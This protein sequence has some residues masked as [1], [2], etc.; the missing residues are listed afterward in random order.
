MSDMPRVFKP[1]T[2][3]R[4][5]VLLSGAALALVLAP[6]VQA[7]EPVF[8][9]EFLAKN[10]NGLQ[11][12]DGDYSDWIEICN[13]STN[14]VNLGG[15]FLT[16]TA[17]DLTKWRIPSTNVPPSGFQL[18]FASGKN[19]AVPGLPLHANFSLS[20]NGEYLALVK[21]D[22]RSIASDFAPQFPPQYADISYGIAQQVQVTRFV[23]SNAPVRVFIPTDGTLGLTW[24]ASDFNDSSWQAATN[25]VG[26]ESYVPGFA[27]RNLRANVGVCDLAMADAVLA[28]PSRQTAV[29]TANP[30]VINY[31]NT[32]SDG[33]FAEG[34]TFPGFTI[35][36]D[37]DNFL[38]EA[39]GVI[40]IPATGNWTFGVNSDDGFRVDLGTN[41]FSYPAPRGAG[42][43]LATFYL[44]AGDYPVRLVFYECGGGSEV[45]FFAAQ[46]AY[47]SFNAAFRLVGDSGGLAVKTLPGS[48][49]STTLRPL[50]ATD[51]VLPMYGKSSSAYVRV[52]FTVADPAVFSSLT[53]RVKYNDG[54][55]AYLNGTKIASRNIP[56][57][58]V[59]NSVATAAR[60]ATIA[61]AYEEIDVTGN[62]SLLRA[63]GNVLALQG[64]NESTSGAQ[65]LVLAE[66]VEN[67]LLGSATN[68]YF[69]TP[70]PGTYNDGAAPAFVGDLKFSPDRGWFQQTNFS[71]TIT[72]ATPGVVIRYTTNGI[73]PSPTNGLLYSGPL[74][75]NG[76]TV[77]RAIGCLDGFE[78]SAVVTHSYLFLD[79][80]QRQSTNV[81]YVGG[82]AGDYTLN[83]N[84][85]QTPPYRDTFISDLLTIPTLSLAISSDDFFGPNGV[86]SNPQGHGV[87][88]ERSC[89]AE[90]MRPDGTKGFHA[91]CGLRIQ[92]GVSR[93]IAK[94]SLRL[95]FKSDYGPSKLNYDLYPDSSVQE[96][97][98]L[99]LHAGFNDQWIWVGAPATLQRDQFCRDTQNAMDG[100]AGHGTYVHL[101]I[102]GLYWGVYNIGEKS[103]NAFAASYLGG[104]KDEYDALTAD[105]LDAGTADAYNTLLALADAGVS[106]DAAYT[107][108]SQYLDIPNFIDYMLM[109]FYAANVDWPGHNWTAARRRLPGAGFHF[110]SWDAEWVLG[111]GSD[112]TT[113]RTGV[114]AGDGVPGRIYAGLR[115]HPEFRRQ[116]GDQAQKFCFNDGPL[117]PGTTQARWAKRAAELDRAI[118]GEAARW[119]G[120]YTRET[121][122]SAESQVVQWFPQRTA[123]LVSQLRNAGL[124][125][126]LNAPGLLP[127][128]GLVPPN[129]TITLTNPSPA[130]TV[131]YT[132][133]GSDP[134]LWGG[135]L[136]PSAKAYI[137]PITITNA[138]FI[139]AR[140]LSGSS[141]STLVEA[142]FYVLQDFGK[143]FVTEIMY[144][145][146][147]FGLTN[148]D[149]V[150]F[151]ELK[152]TGANSLDLSGLQFTSGI[153]FSF[154]NGTRLGPGRFFVLTRNP[155]AF[156]AKYPGV[157]VDGVYGGKLNNNG[158]S[159]TLWH[160]LG[161][162]IFS[163]AYNNATPW[164]ITPDGLGFS[165]VRA[166]Y[167]LEPGLPAAW[168]ASAAAGGSPGADDPVPGI[169]PLL[170]NE[171]L[172]HTD[173]PQIDTIELFN[174]TSTNVNIGGWFLSDDRANPMKFRVPDSI[175]IPPG[176]Y[177][178]FT[179]ADFDPHPGVP[180][181]FALSS[182]GESL[183]LF[184]GGAST[185]L[186]GYSHSL[187]YGPAAN[188]V[189]FGRYVISTGE[190]QWPAQ[191]SLTLGSENSGPRVGHV[192][193]NE[194]QY[195]PAPGYD[196]FVELYNLSAVSV[197]LF[198]SAYPTNGWR[199][200]GLG[201]TFGNVTIPP[202]GYL[203]LVPGD[204]AA[205]RVK[206]GISSAAQVM[207]P[208]PG[209]LQGGGERLRLERPDT[210]DTNGVAYILV[211]EVRYGDHAPWPQGADGDG[212][213]LQR[214][215]P[216]LYGNEPT[217]WFA[218]GITP[219]APNAFNQ[220]PACTLL[221]P[222]DGAHFTASSAIQLRASAY[223]PDGFIVSI[224]FYDGD[225]KLADATNVPFAFTWTNAAV[226]AHHLFAKARD[227][228]LAVG[229][230]SAVE[231]VV[232]P[233]PAGTGT[234]LQGDYYDNIDYTGIHVQRTDPTVYFDWGSGSPDAAIGSDTFSVRWTGEVQPRYTGTYTFYTVSDDGVRLWVNNQLLINNW[235][236]HGSTQD[237][238]L[239]T[240]QAGRLYPIKMEMYENG[241]GAVAQLFWSAPNGVKEVIPSTQ[242]YLPSATNQPP[243]VALTSPIENSAFVAGA[244]VNL[245]ADA[246]DPDGSISRV[247]F[248]AG[249]SKVGSA[250]ALPYSCAWSSVPAGSF[251]LRAVA[252]DNAGL[253]TTSAPVNIS[254][255][256][257]LITNLT[258]V[259][260]GAVWSYGDT[261]ED[262]GT[263]WPMLGFND[264]AW[265]SG[266]ARLGY[267]N[268]GEGTVVGFGMNA[269]G[270][271]ITTYFRRFFRVD[272]AADYD[273][274]TL[275]VLRQDGVLVYLNGSPVARNNLPPDPVNYLTRASTNASAADGI[276]N[277]Y[278]AAIDAGYLVPGTNVIAAEV[279][280]SRPDSPHLAFDLELTGT[281]TFL[282]PWITAQPQ[283]Q[284]STAGTDVTLGVMAQGTGPLYYQW[285]LNGMALPGATD[286]SLS[287]SNIQPAQAGTYTV[288]VTNLAG[289]VVSEP[290]VIN[291]TFLDTD[292]DGMP[293]SWET[294]HGLD[295]GINDANLDPDHDGMTNLQEFLA[296]TDPQDPNSVLRLR[297]APAGSLGLWLEFDA[298]ANHSYTVQRCNALM[299][300]VWSSFA[301]IPM[302]ATNHVVAIPAATANSPGQYFRLVTP[303]Q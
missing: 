194:I 271:Y 247:D 122:L 153:A 82:S 284:T 239:I 173:P 77:L 69:A 245:T 158:D 225:V 282:A 36:V 1:S 51:V 170:I 190:E 298:V 208:Y 184:S 294:A 199:L 248:F 183:Y 174:P 124:F 43:T 224:E 212:P 94:R 234:G 164:P 257:G 290:A 161:T 219:G 215:A 17:G 102:N 152:N 110:F 93:T 64:V 286:S 237:A 19:R 140:V 213:S 35:G 147:D 78:P 141:W 252:V 80:V 278:M 258:F 261:G 163:F 62:L 11:D 120:G 74:P 117:T 96:F 3:L 104:D 13:S 159:L 123:T 40:T 270:K 200:N 81:D 162:N 168:R 84:V 107:N 229:T 108:I 136:A 277:F 274:L 113:D 181:S 236:D 288:R 292:G 287:L 176:G 260:T 151:V 235:T 126:A 50:I 133:D 167:A 192:V 269:T 302:A 160:P 142:S 85:T 100:Y 22:G 254:V 127:F 195:H 240:L 87:A 129:S 143:L 33:N 232:D 16:D 125:P 246:V 6:K 38:T 266:T 146:P 222:A 154:T 297:T 92:G 214:Q 114:G 223:D 242:L 29:F 193:I 259:N 30:G 131:Y 165:L 210:P 303:A 37:E 218:S 70:S 118:V 138:L 47:S 187:E 217:N 112:P 86:W 95:L 67:K 169:A 106:T 76:T 89:S 267:G 209:V 263:A 144:H 68:H 34:A 52:P 300:G 24:T 231:I 230:S 273:S 145:P 65:F 178:T 55:T 203:L 150:E 272:N 25:G 301:D 44:K 41:S 238:G 226:G 202:G 256:A 4:A 191:A 130:G 171:V 5:I 255:Q 180:P 58:P 98:T 197:P 18:V 90:Y 63:G 61:L 91:N 220:S 228:G 241:G 132:V 75:V 10:A 251:S 20:A 182:W 206:Y 27:A 88:W 188:G 250:T 275:R 198:D 9:S 8:I 48:A 60:P 53:L 39:T 49:S 71:V 262:L 295:P 121:W 244:S 280:L 15:W 216:Q 31:L 79:Q 21:P 196:E 296:G 109:N 59:W 103:D 291:V 293:D 26:Y 283:S 45:E 211:D 28:D 227:N 264:R 139:R 72:S 73:A 281:R 155:A 149:E 14:I 135:S 42:D 289:S 134:R 175:R 115:L 57:T 111:V 285:L 83:T 66:L 279:H 156:A 157:A 201:Y 105:E 128:G 179:E 186:T 119:G 185:N 166:N 189:S 233:P 12:E 207:G 116:F 46:G 177:V 205:F 276:T 2:L 172:T 148:G 56:A 221:A 97:D 249:V 101:Y 7:S 32:G 265:S 137:A 54:F 99:T 299:P 243:V 253:S 268:G 23:A 204:P